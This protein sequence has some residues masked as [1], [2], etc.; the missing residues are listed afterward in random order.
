MC[1]RTKID[2]FV[3]LEERKF[4]CIHESFCCRM[5]IED[6]EM[7]QNSA[8]KQLMRDFNTQMSLKEREIELTVKETIG[9]R[10]V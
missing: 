2:P 1:I 7:K 5:E 9:K 6:L 8:L 10:G 3:W 4:C